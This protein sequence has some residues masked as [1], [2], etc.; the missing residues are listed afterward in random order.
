ML[1]QYISSCRYHWLE[2][3][4]KNIPLSHLGR[5]THWPLTQDITFVPTS[6]NPGLQAAW[7][8]AEPNG[9][10]CPLEIWGIGGQGPI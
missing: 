3:T 6:L 10:A 1:V 8:D 2:F 7:A 4:Q 9:V 5:V